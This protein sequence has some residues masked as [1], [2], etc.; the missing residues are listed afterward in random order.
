MRRISDVGVDEGEKKKEAEMRGKL[1][2]PTLSTPG[3]GM[4]KER[5]ATTNKNKQL[6]R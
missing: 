5:A 3:R 1:E 4:R 2:S 6:S